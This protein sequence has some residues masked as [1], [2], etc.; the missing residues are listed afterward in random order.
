MGFRL[1]NNRYEEIKRII[2]ELFIKYDVKC[3]PISG[4]E[5]ASKMGI[6]VVPYSSCA[7]EKQKQ[8]LKISEDGFF[9]EKA[10][11]E[12]YIYY[13]DHQ[14]YGRI[15]NTILH[16]IGHI[17]LDHTEESELAEAEVN[18]F[19]KYALVPPVLVHKLGLKTYYE[20]SEL[21]DVSLKAAIYALKY[22]NK[23]LKYGSENY[24]D[25]ELELINLFSQAM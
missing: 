19:A 11:N 14:N 23:W 9:V 22:Y 21:F 4:F 20:I 8:L 6:R 13:N 10:D 17:V 7:E 16:E 12:F 24:T 18:F 3:I 1:S 15:N 2:V 5:L 25:Y